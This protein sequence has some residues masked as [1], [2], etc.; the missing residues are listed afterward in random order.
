MTYF[1]F[2]GIFLLP[3]L[4]I[5]L[6]ITY[7]DKRSNRKSLPRNLTAWPF[8]SVIFA[9]VLV[10]L[11]YTTPWDN[12]LVAT[13]VWWYDPKLVTGITLGW[14]P[15]EEYTFFILQT[16]TSGTWIG[17]LARRLY[18]SNS[19]PDLL[20]QSISRKLRYGLTLILIPIWLW[21]AIVLGTSW[22]PGNY[23][24]LILIWALPPIMLQ[25]FFGSDILL[26]YSNLL[27][28]SVTSTTVYLSVADYF[29]IRAGTWVI[30]PEKT[31]GIKFG[32]IVPVEEVIF[33]MMT[34]ILISFGM[35]LVL[36][37]ESQKRVPPKILA[38]IA[39]LTRLGSPHKPVNSNSSK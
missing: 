17:I 29:A 19:P 2:L 4:I 24:A 1:G 12:Y 3:L 15:I 38:K 11:I 30:S 18:V 10:A 27:L 35:V 6:I 33:F 14:V 8:F 7:T 5:F 34:N 28:I 22:Q 16:L 37:K 21:S 26:R 20:P 25:T 36:E 23:L 31:L 13:N 32:G 9:H 39:L